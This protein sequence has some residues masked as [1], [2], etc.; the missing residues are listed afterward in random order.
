[1]SFIDLISILLTR[2]LENYLNLNLR[3]CEDTARESLLIDFEGFYLLVC[4][5]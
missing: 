3:F 4:N 1:M 5:F 2:L